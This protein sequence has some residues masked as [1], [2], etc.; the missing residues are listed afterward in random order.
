MSSPSSADKI[1][2]QLSQNGISKSDIHVSYGTGI[3]TVT[4]DQPSSLVLN[5]IEKTGMKAVLKGYGSST[6]KESSHSVFI[7][8]YYS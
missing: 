6:C 8:Y 1:I 2:D 7:L 5:S 4:T 3:V